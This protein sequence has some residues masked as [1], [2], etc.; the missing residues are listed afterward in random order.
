MIY[1]VM[2]HLLS[3]ITSVGSSPSSGLGNSVGNVSSLNDILATYNL[4]VY[5]VNVTEANF[6]TIILG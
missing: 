4:F 2:S 3:L 5:T 6:V 1:H